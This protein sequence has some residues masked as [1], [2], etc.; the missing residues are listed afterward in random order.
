LRRIPWGDYA[1]DLNLAWWAYLLDLRNPNIDGDYVSP[2]TP[3]TSKYQWKQIDTKGSMNE[4][5]FTFGPIIT[6]VLYLGM[7]FGSR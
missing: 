5:V 4:Y 2:I 1:F 3:G 6:T 7:T